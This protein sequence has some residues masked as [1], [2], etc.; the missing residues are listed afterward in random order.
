MALCVALTLPPVKTSI[1]FYQPKKRPQTET[2]PQLESGEGKTQSSVEIM[3]QETREEELVKFSWRNAKSLL[4]SHFT[5]GYKN[6][7]VLQWSLWW[8]LLQ[9]GFR[10]GNMYAQ[11]LWHYIEPER[12]NIFNGFAEAGQTLCGGLA[13]L[14]AGK[15]NQQYVERT[16]TWIMA[17]CS[18]GMGVLLLVGGRTSSVF[19][20]Y[21]MYILFGATYYFMLVGCR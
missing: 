16:A 10:M 8:S 5:S 14:L 1:Y 9:A 15:L 6:S 7:T 17:V 19:V 18:I 20:S 11:P 12:E 3:P 2:A 13:A 21:A 4:W